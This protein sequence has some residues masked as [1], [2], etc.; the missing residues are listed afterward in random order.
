MSSSSEPQRRV[1][2]RAV[3]SMPRLAFTDNLFCSFKSFG[4]HGIPQYKYTGAFWER[5]IAMAFEAAIGD[6]VEWVF[7]TDYDTVF[8]REDVSNMM[9]IMAE[10]PD[11][12]ALCATQMK[13]AV[14]ALM[15]NPAIDGEG[16]GAGPVEGT[17]TVS[18]DVFDG[19]LTRVEASHFG[20]TLLRVD[21]IASMPKPWFQ[22][23]PAPDGTWGEGHLDADWFFWRQ[24]RDHGKTLYQANSIRIGH[25]E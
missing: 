23:L 2:I 22:S 15:A 11:I 8:D 16:Q 20:L 7:T 9:R 10:R 1:N 3:I 14:P 24:W 12:D 5:G 13:R 25:L 18:L 4:A 17:K 21:S 6:G 19:E